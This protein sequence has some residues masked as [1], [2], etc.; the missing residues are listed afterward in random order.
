MIQQN[1]KKSIHERDLGGMGGRNHGIHM[2]PA[3]IAILL[4]RAQKRRRIR[5]TEVQLGNFRLMESAPSL[6]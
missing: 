1:V 4:C 2:G 3:Q 5:D 6:I